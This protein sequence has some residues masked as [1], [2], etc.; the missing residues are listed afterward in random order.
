MPDSDYK[1]IRFGKGQLSSEGEVEAHLSNDTLESFEQLCD[2][3]GKAL[4]EG[5]NLIVRQ[6]LEDIKNILGKEHKHDLEQ[7]RSAPKSP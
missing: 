2:S 7:D 3:L 6:L 1:N 4:A 5:Q